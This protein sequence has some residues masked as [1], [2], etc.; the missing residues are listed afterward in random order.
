ME[1]NTAYVQV[2]DSL[3]FKQLL[4]IHLVEVQTGVPMQ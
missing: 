2:F 3:N 4:Y 1:A